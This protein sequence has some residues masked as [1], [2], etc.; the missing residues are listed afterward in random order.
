MFVLTLVVL[1]LFGCEHQSESSDAQTQVAAE[2]VARIADTYLD[3]FFA[4]TPE[5][6]T[7]FG[8]AGVDHGAVSDLSPE[9][10]RDWESKQDGWYE[11]LMQI[12]PSDLEGRSEWILH[13]FL[14]ERLQA[15]RQ[16]R[17]C[18]TELW[19]VDQMSG[20][21]VLYPM[22]TALQPL[23]SD[24]TREAALTRFG[25]LPSVID[26]EIANLEEGLRL[27]YSSPGLVVERVTAQ[28]DD[29]I[30]TP[31]EESP[32]FALAH[33]DS[34]EE[35][36]EAVVTLIRDSI[37]PATR[38]YRDYLRDT[39]LPNARVRADVAANP[40]GSECYRALIRDATTLDR[41]PEEIHELGLKTMK[42]IHAEMRQISEASFGGDD[43]PVLMQRLRSEP[44]F[45]FNNA[46]E[47][48]RSAEEAIARAKVEMPNWFGLI[49]ASD[50]VVEPIPVFEQASA[51]VGSYV[52]PS[53]DGTRPGIYRINL[54]SPE[55]RPRA[56]H[57]AVAFHEGI[58]GH[59]LQVAIA[60]ERA[61]SH[62]LTRYLFMT[63]FVEGWALYS[64]RLADEMGLY[65]SELSRLGMLSNL[66][67]RAARLVVD[68][69]IHAL[70]WSRQ[71]AIDYMAANTA[72]G[73]REIE[74]EVDRYIIMP[75]QATAYMVGNLEIQR[76]R[77]LSEERLGSSFKIS[78]FHDLILREGAVTLPMLADQVER[79]IEVSQ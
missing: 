39:Y 46:D 29:L 45:R 21:Q 65:S 53:E 52:P 17:V 75:G 14:R 40:N 59:H 79:W 63:S 18:R 58:P 13:G 2:S 12:D 37:Q 20:W 38:R 32:F 77:R 48:Q 67:L 42:A 57:E 23:G 43:I 26:T 41:S 56:P 10:T 61:S 16:M 74:I 22:L 30:D 34:T 5:Y 73:L 78:D 64:E 36:R 55:E 31:A 24:E 11:E 72:E 25:S 19:P 54:G 7:F 50:V 15:E 47:I 60:A 1:P 71:E 3:E 51:P 68:T 9:A 33:R 6:A 70:G 76:L 44:Q 69:G 28:L 35:F 4:F 66:A 8:V 62:P 49:P 27:G